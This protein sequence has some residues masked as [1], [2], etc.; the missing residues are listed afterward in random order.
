M[1]LPTSRNTNYVAGV[2]Q[3]KSADLNDLQDKIID[4]HSGKHASKTHTVSAERMR[5]EGTDWAFIVNLGNTPVWSHTS[6]VTSYLVV[7]APNEVGDRI[8]AARVFC[9]L[10]T[11]STAALSARL[12]KVNATTGTAT[13]KSDAV[14]TANT[15]AFQ[16]ITLTNVANEAI[17]V[18]EQWYVVLTTG[19]NVVKRVHAA[20]YTYDHP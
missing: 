20:E 17:A 13:A 5:A 18:N 10:D 14:S 12:Y 16:T 4:L 15:T 7:P 8:S 19:A 2:S 11:G 3:V 9:Q 6:A 1:A